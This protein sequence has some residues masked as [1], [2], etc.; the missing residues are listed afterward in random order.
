MASPSN[1]S[2]RTS[3]ANVGGAGCRAGRA[4]S[5]LPCSHAMASSKQRAILRSS[6][7]WGPTLI[8]IDEFHLARHPGVG[9]TALEGDQPMLLVPREAAVGDPVQLWMWET[10]S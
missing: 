8:D 1:S 7:Q 3:S 6:E 9:V 2:R 5:S 4:G 10:R